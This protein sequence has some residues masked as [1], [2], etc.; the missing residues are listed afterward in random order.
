MAITSELLGK[1]GGADVEVIPVSATVSTSDPYILYIGEIPPGQIG[2]VFV[3]GTM[4][5]YKSNRYYLPEIGISSTTA[6]FN[7]EGGVAESVT[8]N[9]QVYMQRRYS[10][11]TDSFEGNVYIVYE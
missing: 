6:R 4:D 1:L 10:S 11:R 5:A 2:K 3:I 8:G 9:F 7:G